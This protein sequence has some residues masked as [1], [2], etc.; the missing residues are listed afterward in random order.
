MVYC[1]LQ[2]ARVYG[3]DH[4][5]DEVSAANEALKRFGI[6]GEARCGDAVELMFPSNHFDA[7]I[8]SDFLEHI[9]E[10]VKVTVLRE[11]RRVPKPEG[12]LVIKTPNLSYLKL[13][14]F[15]KRMRAIARL[16][17]PLKILIPHTPGTDDP[18]HIGLTTR[19]RLTRSLTE[20]GFINYQFFYAPLRRLGLSNFVE[21]L[22]TEIPGVRDLICEDVFCKTFKPIALSHFPD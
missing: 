18:Q 15:Y 17:N 6:E 10:A 19:R 21:I 8:S 22:S 16:R 9:T 2:G 1:G 20:A 4:N 13:S 7:V 5:A 3:Q 11:I 14:L 12:T